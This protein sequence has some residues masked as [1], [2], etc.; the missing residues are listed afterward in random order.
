MSEFS[1]EDT[2][3]KSLTQE[4][5]SNSEIEVLENDDLD[6]NKNSNKLNKILK[7]KFTA[8]GKDYFK[9][10]ITNLALTIITI[11]IYYPWAKARQQRYFWAHTIVAD[12]A[13]G[14]HGR[15][16][17]MFK[18]YAIAAFLSALYYGLSKISP[19][20]GATMLIFLALIYPVLFRASS[21]FLLLN[22]SWRG[23]RFKFKASVKQSYQYLA[24]S[25]LV[26]CLI[27]LIPL[28]L[29]FVYGE[30]VDD[31][32]NKINWTTYTPVFISTLL[33]IVFGFPI[34]Y[35]YIKKFQRDFYSFANI[36]TRFNANVWGFFK[37]LL[38]TAA[39]S[40]LVSIIFGL[41]GGL[42]SLMFGAFSIFSV[43]S[44]SSASKSNIL[45]FLIYVLPLILFFG[46]FLYF[47]VINSYFNS[48]HF[49][50]FWGNIISN[51]LK[52]EA[53]LKLKPLIILNSKNWILIVLSLG[54]YYP[55]A[56][57]ASTRMQLESLSIYSSLDFNQL[58]SDASIE[59]ESNLGQAM[60]D[61]FDFDFGF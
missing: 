43:F 14:F 27:T 35:F 9:V 39:V 32:D 56:K 48:R 44:S 22:T 57:V 15:A 23:L 55:F 5:T 20:Y 7:I 59:D 13:L 12:H 6:L 18:G 50:F 40:M 52:M 2:T 3:D 54:L 60:S 17:S 19:E 51:D 37:V 61:L 26:S 49:N 41:I 45:S 29:V 33:L 4:N 1:N 53:D 58:V 46:Y 31:F 30:S 11:G 25:I 28:I 38:K 34:A 42:F 24:S 21:R 16:Q 10:W 8:K 47:V 36:Q